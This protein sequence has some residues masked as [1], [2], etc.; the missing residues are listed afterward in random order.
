MTRRVLDE[1]KSFSPNVLCLDRRHQSPWLETHS[2]IEFALTSTLAKKML[3][4]N[5]IL[6]NLSPTSVHVRLWVTKYA[7]DIC[8]FLSGDVYIITVSPFTG[9]VVSCL[10]SAHV[11]DN[12]SPLR[13]RTYFHVRLSLPL[14]LHPALV[15]RSEL[16]EHE[17]PIEPTVI[18]HS[19]SLCPAL[20]PLIFVNLFGL[21]S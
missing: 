5:F 14:Y 9:T 16:V 18:Y 10:R 7:N 2:R 4:E 1:C 6:V 19:Y 3:H 20:V 15:F 8:T 11:V 21:V 12:I 17:Y 13:P